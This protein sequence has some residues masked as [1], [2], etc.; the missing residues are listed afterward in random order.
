MNRPLL[1]REVLLSPTDH[2]TL[3]YVH[4]VK[5]P[6][7]MREVLLSPTDHLTLH[8]VHSVNQP[9]LMREVLLS[10][11]DHKKLNKRD[12]LE[13]LS[14]NVFRWRYVVLSLIHL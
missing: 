1:M 9:L 12:D 4:R 11:T 8:Y 6:L 5:Q 2:L 13:P 10:P 7:L 14:T 3:H